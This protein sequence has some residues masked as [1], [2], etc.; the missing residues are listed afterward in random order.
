MYQLVIAPN[1]A[2]LIRHQESKEWSEVAD[3]VAGRIHEPHFEYLART[4]C[5]EH[6]SADTLGGTASRVARLSS[7][8]GSIERTMRLTLWSSG[9]RRTKPTESSL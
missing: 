4:W 6:A 1:E 7:G 5:A 2:R 8:V 3:T 9:P